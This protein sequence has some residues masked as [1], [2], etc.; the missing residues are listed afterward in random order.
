MICPEGAITEVLHRTGTVEAGSSG[1]IA[2][3][4]GTLDVG[5][6]MAPAVIKAVKRAA[7]PADIVFVDAPPGT[8]CPVI[9][10]VRDCDYVLLVAEPTPFGLNDLRLAV[11]MVRILQLPFGVVINR[12][13][14]GDERTESYCRQEGIVVHGRIPDDRRIA[15]AY[16]RGELVCSAVPGCEPLFVQ[17]FETICRHPEVRA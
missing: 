2:F 15:E 1:R 13:D 6:V 12:A 4:R 10:S 11:D 9:E 7:P 16:S 17:L 14:I 3:V 5:Q 8:S